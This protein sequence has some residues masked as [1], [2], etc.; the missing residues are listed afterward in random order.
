MAKRPI[1]HKFE[2]LCILRASGF[3]VRIMKLG[4]SLG[5]FLALLG[6][7]LLAQDIPTID[8]ELSKEEFEEFINEHPFKNRPRLTPQQIKKMDKRDRP[9]L[10]WEQDF[11]RTLD[12][13]TGKPERQRLYQYMASVSTGAQAGL[14]PGGTS[15]NPWTERGPN[16]I[17]GRTRALLWDPNSSNKVWAGGVTGGLWYN[18]DITSSSST[19]NKVNDFWDNIAVTAIAADPNN[20]DTMYV[21]TGEGWGVG[22]SI[23]GG[24]WKSTDGGSTWNLLTSTT[25][26]TSEM[27]YVNDIIVR[28]ESG[29][30]VVYAAVSRMFY[31]GVFHG[32]QGLFR[33]TNHGTSW[34][35]VMPNISGS[36]YAPADIELDAGNRIWVGTRRNSFGIGG[37]TILRSD[38]GT[39]WTTAYTS[40]SGRRVELATAPSDQNY[41]YALISGLSGGS[42]VL[43]EVKQSTDRG[44][45]WF[46]RN[47]PND[48]DLGIPSTDFTRG[49]AWY[50][51]IIQVDPNE[52]RTIIA[53]GIDLFRSTNGGISWTQI[54]KWSNN[55][56]LNTLSCPLVHA[57]QHQVMFKPG[58]S[59]EVIFGT[60]GGVYY[61]DTVSSAA[62]NSSAIN[63]RNNGYN[64]TQFYS[65]ALHPTAGNNHMLAGSQDNGTIKLNSAGI[66]SGT[67]VRGGDGAFC[68]ID[69]NQSQFQIASYVYNTYYKST[70]GGASFFTI[71]ILND[72]TTGSFINPADYDDNQNILFSNR[73]SSSIY[74][75]KNV[76]GS[77]SSDNFSIS[78]G[79]DASAFKVSP[80][81]TSS[82]KLY[83]GTEGGRVYRITNAD[84]SSPSA[85]RIDGSGFPSGAVSCVQIGGSEDTLLVTFFNYG[86]NSVWYSTN[87]GTSWTNKDN[88][89][90]PDMPI[91]WALFNPH[92]QGEVILATDI[93]VWYCDNINSGT[94]TWSRSNNGFANVRVDMLQYRSSDST[95]MAATHGRGVFTSKFLSATVP[96]ASFTGT[97]TSICPGDTVVYTDNTTGSVTS[98]SWSFPGGSPSSSTS[99]T[100]SVV[101]ATAGNYNAQLIATNAA[102]SDT[103]L[104][105]NYITVNSAPSVSWPAIGPFC[106]ND[107]PVTLSG[108]T[109]AGGSYSGTAVSSGVFTP[110]TAGAGSHVLFYTVTNSNGCTANSSQTV[111]VN[112]TGGAS[113]NSFA[114][115][116]DN[117]ASF[118]LT[119]GSPSGGSYKVNGVTSTS[120]DPASVGAGTQTITYVFTTSAGCTDSSSQSI[121]VHAQ[122]VVTLGSLADVCLNDPI[123]NLSGG[124]P[125]GGSFSGSGV[126][127]TTFD[128][129][130][131]GVGTHPI[132]YRFTDSNSCTDSA[133]QNQ[134]VK[135]IPII[136]ALQDTAIC[137][138][139]TANFSV[140]GG[141]TYA[142]SP[143]AS[144][145]NSTSSTPNAFPLVT[146]KYFVTGTTI[147]GCSNYDSILVTVN[148]FPVVSAGANQTICDGQITSLSAT[149]AMT[150]SWTP[151]TGLSRSTSANP[152]VNTSSSITYTVVGTDMNSCFSSDSVSITVDPSPIVTAGNDTS[153]CDD[154]QYGL[155]ASGA[156]SYVWS[157]SAGLDNP[158]LA[159][160]TLTVSGPQM[161]TV[162][163][164]NTFGC[165]DTSSVMITGLALPNVSM[166]AISDRCID[167]SPFSLVQGSP[168][169]GSYSGPGVSS[170]VLDPADA[171]AGSHS[172]VYLF[173]DSNGC[174]NSVSEIAVV[175]PLPLVSIVGLN[176]VYCENEGADPFTLIPA[177]GGTLT[178]SGIVGN[179]FIPSSVAVGNYPIQYDYTDTNG[180]SDS[181]SQNVKVAKVPSVPEVLGFKFVFKG[182]QY[183]Y[184]VENGPNGATYEWKV[185][186][187]TLLATAN[188]VASILWSSTAKEGTITLVQTS[189]DGCADS[190]ETTIFIGAVSVE[191]LSIEERIRIFPNPADQVL[192]V[193]YQAP[194][195]SDELEIQI[196]D[197]SGRLLMTERLESSGRQYGAQISLHDLPSGTYLIRLMGA[198]EMYQ[199]RFIRR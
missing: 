147:N 139:D 18:N 96:T 78:M 35:Q 68:F 1:F 57:D 12:P 47:E 50:D 95:V 137:I 2:R 41:L 132:V 160:P 128:P 199:E 31:N 94:P 163:G 194:S 51:L 135:P 175:N 143:S 195:S 183:N 140:G 105:T 43:L 138:G 86:V 112:A 126:S 54:S 107:A 141:I 122:P 188:T 99:P 3:K 106:A 90:L 196:L 108:G 58:S 23:G 113:L 185:K 56:N 180:C 69:Q 88:S 8:R 44:V 111:T 75:V 123:V 159:G 10:A 178:G 46:T 67:E 59:E 115:I 26:G 17:G 73:N 119:G 186:N 130:T 13:A 24:I 36:P 136:R 110:S 28:D 173:T 42:E 165:S 144:L 162:I 53:G 193:E 101:Y 7:Q 174:S 70:N 191:D 82:S 118:T 190:T 168:I 172:I 30:S 176:D 103:L 182:T 149:G 156:T 37:G 40:A 179:A 33:S 133:T 19:W 11:L 34:T 131:A 63:S 104:Q 48:A 14:T 60:D 85:T 84:G 72:Q 134:I 142:W 181:Y 197:V 83:V 167:A 27:F 77:H 184:R 124:S 187:G 25:T 20:P 32:D 22:A 81:T 97:P 92:V 102:G 6:G 71:N 150:Y 169:G 64:V 155:L 152:T 79:T 38:N 116:C 145:D 117:E 151:A 161:Y 91:R 164:T 45:S 198:E 49:Q 121:T 100:V 125:S 171:G 87:G 4:A 129:L 80:H 76:T 189:A 55:A 158:N 109:P 127:G 62:T 21:G 98:R 146:T 29:S 153:V 89:S 65:A 52:R 114:P 16:D 93:G 61:S 166:T 15:S 170:G 120:F 74:R 157:P 9:D 148:N 177:S 66:G 5:L 39:S 154:E 192:N